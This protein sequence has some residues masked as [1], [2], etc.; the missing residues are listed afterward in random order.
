MSVSGRFVMESEALDFRGIVRLDAKQSQL[1]AGVKS[2]FL[3]VVDG[4]LRRDDITVVPITIWGSS[5]KP[6]VWGDFGKA[7]IGG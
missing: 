4:L 2:F 1:T 6:N 7:I 3:R 5:E